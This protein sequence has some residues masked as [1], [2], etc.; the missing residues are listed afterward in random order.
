MTIPD[1][2]VTFGYPYTF[3]C[4]PECPVWIFVNFGEEVE[5]GIHVVL[6][7]AFNEVK[8]SWIRYGNKGLGYDVKGLTVYQM[9]GPMGHIGYTSFR[10]QRWRW[11]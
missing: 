3:W 8:D 10:T 11:R 7:E 4:A 1:Q 6:T 2:T 9:R 5:P